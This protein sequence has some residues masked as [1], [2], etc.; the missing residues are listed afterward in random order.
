MVVEGI[1]RFHDKYGFLRLPVGGYGKDVSGK[2][3]CR[4]PGA[5]TTDL[6]H[7]TVE[8]HLDGCVTVTPQIDSGNGAGVFRL[9]RGFWQQC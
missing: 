3:W 2:W 5:D 7:H 9:D 6:S 4:P 8:E 1:R